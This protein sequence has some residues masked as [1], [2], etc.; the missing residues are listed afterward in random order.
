MTMSSLGGALKCPVRSEAK[1]REGAISDLTRERSGKRDAAAVNHVAAADERPGASPK[2]PLTCAR[3]GSAEIFIFPPRIVA[4]MRLAQRI[5]STTIARRQ[6][7]L[8]DDNLQSSPR[9]L[10]PLKIYNLFSNILKEKIF[11][12]LHPQGNWAD[13]GLMTSSSGAE[14]IFLQQPKLRQN[15]FHVVISTSSLGVDIFSLGHSLELFAA[16]RGRP[17][18]REKPLESGQMDTKLPAC[19]RRGREHQRAGDRRHPGRYGASA[20]SSSAV[21][22]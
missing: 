13:V 19:A 8:A 5:D 7:E 15:G 9:I 21:P 18:K 6:R 14:N 16:R 20:R 17:K 10:G 1:H 12:R 2:K 4:I 22:C 11:W 3:M